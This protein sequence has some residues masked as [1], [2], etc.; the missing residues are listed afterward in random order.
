MGN[1]KLLTKI[2][3]GFFALSF[4]F[5]MFQIAVLLKEKKLFSAKEEDKNPAI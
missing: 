2:Q 1:E 5:V 3:I 4:V